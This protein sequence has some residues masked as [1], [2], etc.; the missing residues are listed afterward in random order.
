MSHRVKNSLAVVAG[1]LALQARGSDDEKVKEALVDARTRV[2]AVAAVHD[3]LWRQPTLGAIDVSGFLEALCGKLQESARRNVIRCETV[4]L[5]IPADLAIPLGLFVN[6]LVTNAIKYAYP[7][8][9]GEIRVTARPH[10]EGGLVIGVADD[11]A[12][13]PDG[14]DP[15]Q[16]RS[17]SLGMRIINNLGRQLGGPLT[18]APDV[19]GAHFSL[20][21]VLPS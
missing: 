20:R 12:G 7:D 9:E 18:V 2:E 15:T 6:E 5:D 11:G 14:F 13:L 19:K 8:G 16:A 3:Q 17:A 1:F 10:E 21:M 4:R